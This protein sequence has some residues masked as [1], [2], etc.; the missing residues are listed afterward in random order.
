M[1][2]GKSKGKHRST[3]KKLRKSTKITVNQYFKDFIDGQRV[4][5]DIESASS[6]SMPC[7]RFQGLTG[8]VIGRRGRA[9]II[10]LKDCNKIKK[11]ITP[12]EHLRAIQ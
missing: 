4:V 11:V 7:R 3:R 5:I 12:S 10:K 9:Y 6:E 8:E 1:V 2:H